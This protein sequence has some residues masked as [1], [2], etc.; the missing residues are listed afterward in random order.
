MQKDIEYIIRT[1]HG[2]SKICPAIEFGKI[3]KVTLLRTV[4]Q[5][6]P[7]EEKVQ[8]YHI[9]VAQRQDYWMTVYRCLGG[10]SQIILPLPVICALEENGY[11]YADMMRK[12]QGE[13]LQPFIAN[14]YVKRLFF[15]RLCIFLWS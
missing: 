15:L 10:R 7:V 3:F 8:L 9:W 12:Q 4:T 13:V 1:K 5:Y 11:S 2:L 14:C 6:H